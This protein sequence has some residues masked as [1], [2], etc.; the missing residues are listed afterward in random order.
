MTNLQFITFSA[1]RFNQGLKGAKFRPYIVCIKENRF[2]PHK[3]KDFSISLY[4]RSRRCLDE[5]IFLLSKNG[6]VNCKEH[7]HCGLI[8]C[9]R[10]PQC[11]G[12][13]EIG[14]CITNVKIFKPTIAQISP[15]FTVSLFTPSRPS[16]T[17]NSFTWFLQ[18]FH[19]FLRE[20]PACFHA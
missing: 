19:L 12:F 20:K 2:L 17:T 1:H 8:H 16:E 7:T 9:N 4:K 18:Y 15:A 11:L 10:W 5:I 14:N 3:S 13:S 6:G